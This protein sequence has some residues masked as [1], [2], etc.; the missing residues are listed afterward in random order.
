MRINRK[1]AAAG[2]A[3]VLALTG[4][5]AFADTVYNDLDNSIDA[6]L[7][8]LNLTYD[9][10]AMSGTTG[11]TKLSIQVDGAP[12]HPGCNIQGGAHYITLTPTTGTPGVAAVSLSNGGRFDACSD[13]VTATVE[14]IGIG[15]TTVTFAISE[16]NTSNDPHLTF[17]LGEAAFTVNVEEGTGTP[18]GCDA[19]PAAPAWAAAILQKSGVKANSGNKNY[20][21]MI[22]NEMG[23]GATF[24]GFAKNAHPQYENAVHA[25]LQTLTGKTLA[26]AQ[27]AARPGWVCTA[28]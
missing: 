22:A 9:S 11:T 19:D 25:R 17:R 15:S 18:V 1:L 21:S 4:P 27:S 8:V 28:Q 16:S 24:G 20:V 5:S 10:L 6:E 12:D 2:A 13:Q 26:S 14:A 7:E 3:C 23:N